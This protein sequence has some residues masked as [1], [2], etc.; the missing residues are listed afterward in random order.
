VPNSKK[1]TGTARSRGGE[2]NER[3]IRFRPRK[4]RRPGKGEPMAWSIALRTVFRYAIGSAT[5]KHTSGA[6]AGPRRVGRRRFNQRCAV[7]VTYTPNRVAG[8]W[9]AHGR[10]LGRESATQDVASAGFDAERTSIDVAAALESWQNAGD[11]RLWKLIISPEFGER[12]DLQQL[13]RHVLGRMEGDLGT[14][15]KWAAVAHFNTDH[16]HVHVAIRGVRDDGAA[17]DLKRDYIRSGIRE[18]AEDGCTMQLGIRTEQDAAMAA[19]K[20]VHQH[21][22]TSLDR[23]IWR[24]HVGDESDYPLAC[25]HFEITI[26]VGG[27]S[28]GRRRIEAQHV[29]ARLVALGKMGM[30]EQTGPNVW[31]VR[32]DFESVLRAMQRANDRQKMAA[33]GTMLSD[34]R[35]QLVVTD[36]RK[37]ENIAGRVIGHGEE[38]DGFQTGR[39]YLLLEG[40]DGVV[41]LLYRTPEMEEARSRGHLSVNSFVRLRRRFAAGRLEIEDLGDSEALLTNKRHLRAS[42]R[43]LFT[44]RAEPVEGGWSGWL[45][46]YQAALSQA[47]DELRG[48]G[49]RESSR[50]R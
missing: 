43:E 32:N 4:P 8:Q 13:T 39:N 26:D 23:S 9:K 38:E 24:L 22:Y 21:R 34:P 50:D 3:K 12:I 33:H 40:T 7:R 27:H 41:H 29:C 36:P 18:I 2:S 1:P 45:G 47:T 48:K 19:E 16:P 6:G 10:Y 46:R 49:S 30:A 25:N 31:R 11:Q 44:R 14:P 37:V 17:L 15:L 42:A 20:E 28:S 5:K 35:L